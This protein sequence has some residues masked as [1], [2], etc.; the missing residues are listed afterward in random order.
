VVTS[1]DTRVAFASGADIEEDRISYELSVERGQGGEEGIAQAAQ[2]VLDR[3][4]WE[5]SE[6]RESS[7]DARIERGVDIIAVRADRTELHIQV[8]RA[9]QDQQLWDELRR[10]GRARR[11]GT[12]DEAVDAL[13]RTVQHKRS[14]ADPTLVLIIDAVG[15]PHLALPRV[16]AAFLAKYRSQVAAVGFRE[17]WLS[18]PLPERT[19]RLDPPPPRV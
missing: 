1:A 7:G 4:G 13:W 6:I 14:R 8:T 15:A 16:V 10:T 12:I 11:K 18:G 2:H 17:V 19:V 9:E 5:G 3:M